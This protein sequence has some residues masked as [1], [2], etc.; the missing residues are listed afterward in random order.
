MRK[1][2]TEKKAE[3]EIEKKS[4]RLPHHLVGKEE[5]QKGIITFKVLQGRKS[6]GR[7]GRK[8]RLQTVDDISF[9]DGPN[10]ED[11]FGLLDLPPGVY[12]ENAT[13]QRFVCT[14]KGCEKED[15]LC[16]FLEYI[17]S[18]ASVGGEGKKFKVISV[19]LL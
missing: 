11:P 5:F 18:Y 8:G 16:N 17:N 2:K 12:K 1:R 19:K 9:K 3:K 6:K 14:N 10:E 15:W 13:L 4:C 7:K